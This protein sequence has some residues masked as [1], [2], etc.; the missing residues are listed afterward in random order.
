MGFRRGCFPCATDSGFGVADNAV[1]EVDEACLN[2]GSQGEDDRGGVAA[3]VGDEASVADLVSVKLGAAV[4]GFGL[5]E[6]RVLGVGVFELIDASIGAVPETPCTAEVDDLDAP[7]DGFGNPLAGLLVGS[8]EEQDLDSAVDDALPSEGED[9]VG[10]VACYRELRVDV[11]EAEVCGCV[12]FSGAAEKCRDGFAEPGMMQEQARKFATR[13]AADTGDCCSG[14][15]GAR[16]GLFKYVRRCGVSQDS[17]R[18]VSSRDLLV[19]R[20]DR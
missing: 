2:E 18:F 7:L 20:P 6:G 12:G 3:G 11:F 19:F 1:V 8:G 14:S 17:L 13:V 15:G 10:F 9:L 4:D 5:E 16:G